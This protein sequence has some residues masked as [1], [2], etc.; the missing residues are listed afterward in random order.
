[1]G[2]ISI[3]DTTSSFSGRRFKPLLLRSKGNIKEFFI[4]R[5]GFPEWI[6]DTCRIKL[7]TDSNDYKITSKRNNDNG[8]RFE[9]NNESKAILTSTSDDD[10]YTFMVTKRTRDKAM[11]HYVSLYEEVSLSD[12]KAIY[13]NLRENYEFRLRYDEAGEF[14]IREMELKRNYRQITQ[15][16]AIIRNSWLRRNLSVT[17]FYRLLNYGESWVGPAILSGLILGISTLILLMQYTHS[18]AVTYKYVSSIGY[19]FQNSTTAFLQLKNE[20]LFLSDYI[21]KALGI[22]SL[23]LFA[24]PLRRKFERK[25]RH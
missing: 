17:G 24:L 18:P 1:M 19:A 6:K 23:G 8:F 3:A 7:E 2:K 20:H 4:G 16:S 14:F 15:D 21:I 22:V 5:P 25:F 12:L 10:F 11:K 9:L 13:R